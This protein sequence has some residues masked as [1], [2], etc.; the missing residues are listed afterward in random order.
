MTSV[1]ITAPDP[2]D[3]ASFYARLL[4]RPVTTKEWPRPGEPPQAGW[5]QIKP[6]DGSGEPTLNFE[7]E[8]QWTAPTW[9]S[10]PGAQHATQHL[11]IFV[12]DLGA[13]TDH[14]VRVGATLATVQ[15]QES[16]RVFFDPAGH[17]FCLFT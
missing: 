2:R 16:V 1:T 12:A 8:A 14:A 10:E 4:G 6:P 3:L 11:D 13:A 17:P 7:Y 9:P 15:P 5:A